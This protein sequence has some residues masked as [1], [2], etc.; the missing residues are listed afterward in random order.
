[1][2]TGRWR[3]GR[4]DPRDGQARGPRLTYAN[5]TA[6]LALFIALG[7]TS[8]AVTK[9]PRNSVGSAQVRNGSLQRQDLS[10]SAVPRIRGPRG[11]AGPSGTPGERGPSS[12]R[13]APPAGDVGLSGAA[14]VQTL[15]RRM[16]NV[17]AGT[18]DLRFFGSP[19]LTADTALHVTCQIK[20]NGDV[21]ASG[22]TVAG[23]AA[24]GT[25]EAGLP[26]ETAVSRQSSFNITV[27]C[28]QNSPSSPA[29]VMNRPQIVATQ[30][31][32][33]TMVP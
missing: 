26:V 14:A 22:A 30:V 27:D 28:S 9:L 8:Y 12:V 20:V 32:D 11:P 21:V 7:G 23:N 1:M 29:V 31:A 2:R 33:L 17:P 15:V 3:A 6:S 24:N 4:S 13:F 18:W 25:Q 16:D 10:R 19:R 5:V